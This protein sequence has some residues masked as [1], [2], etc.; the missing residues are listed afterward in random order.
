MG[1]IIAF[2]HQVPIPVQMV[3]S[4]YGKA[5]TPGSLVQEP[6]VSQIVPSVPVKAAE[7]LMELAVPDGEQVSE[8]VVLT[9]QQF[10]RK[11]KINRW[12]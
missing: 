1:K 10:R 9:D 4:Q 2:T 6:S 5:G 3:F 11:R 7:H 12:I 8:P